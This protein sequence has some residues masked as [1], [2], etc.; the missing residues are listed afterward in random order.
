MVAWSQEM[1]GK[2][3]QK[4]ERV[5]DR[6]FG[7]IPY[8]AEDGKYNDLSGG[9]VD[10]WT[11]GFF[12]GSLWQLYQWNGNEAFKESAI[13]IEKKLDHALEDF[14]GLHHDVGFM[15]LHT[16][17]ADYRITGN[18]KSKKRGLHAASLLLARFNLNGR[19][20][21]AWNCEV[22]GWAIIDSMMNIPILYWASEQL[23]D[24]RYL[25]VAKAHADTLEKY[26]VRSDGSVG[27][28]AEFDPQSGLFKK[29]VRG[30]GYS[31][32]SS[33]SRGQ[34]W[35]IYG[36]ALSYRY[37]KE[38]HYLDTAKKI[39]NY[40]IGNVSQTEAVPLIDFRAPLGTT[41]IDTSA[42][43]CAACGFLEIAEHLSGMEARYYH[44][45]AEKILRELAD[46]Y[47]DLDLEKDGMLQKSSHSYHQK[48]ETEI[49]LVYGD[50][51]FIE[52]IL[53][54]EDQAL[55]IW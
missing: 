46:N 51:F 34:A 7:K 54:L 8:S 14:V 31:P 6:N 28:I 29:L 23:G 19:Y 50:Y 20:L 32:E 38:Q 22:P 45:A 53:R 1:L 25:Q 37:T 18:E 42:G 16:A 15:W 30:Q 49:H 27:H 35:A 41:K 52:G 39:A 43:A 12:A 40:F 44:K 24:P 4:M 11:N 21:V 9:S 55:A 2:I 17:V 13:A 33:W 3:N 5:N 48:A 10:W 36:F 47:I 26:L